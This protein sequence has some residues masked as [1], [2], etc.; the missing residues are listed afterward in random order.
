MLRVGGY[1]TPY[2]PSEAGRGVP[3][4]PGPGARRR[5]PFPGVLSMSSK[6]RQFKL[7]DVGEGLTE[8]EILQWLV[9]VGDTGSPSTSR[10]ARSRRRRPRSSCR[11][12]YA[13]TVTELLFDAGTMVDVGTPIIT[14]DVGGGGAAPAGGAAPPAQAARPRRCVRREPSCGPDRRRRTGPAGGP[15]VLVGYGRGT[16]RP[17]VGRA[18]PGDTVAARGDGAGGLG[19]APRCRPRLRRDGRTRHCSPRRPTP[20]T[21]P[22]RHGGLEV[23][24]QGRGPR[25]GRWRGRAAEGAEHGHRRPRP[26]A[27]PPV[28]KYAKDLGVDLATLTGTGNGGVIARADVDAAGGAH[29]SGHAVTAIGVGESGSGARSSGSRSRACASTRPRRWWPARSPRRTSPSSSPST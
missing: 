21:K 6:L 15:A 3:A 24:R 18:A 27:K 23:G 28:G 2:P 12:P 22:V 29:P 9:A 20:S 7:P 19:R 11:R 25:T 1:D 26:L 8:G 16:P 10:C 13:G 14:I 17:A 5:R 4:R